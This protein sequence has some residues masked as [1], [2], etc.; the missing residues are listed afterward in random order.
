ME[1]LWKPFLR[2]KYF[3]K[4]W[5]FTS[6]SLLFFKQTNCMKPVP[7]FFKGESPSTGN[8]CNS[9]IFFTK[10]SISQFSRNLIC[11]FSDEKLQRLEIFTKNLEHLNSYW[12]H[13]SPCFC[14]FH[15]KNVTSWGLLNETLAV[16]CRIAARVFLPPFQMKK[17]RSCS[18]LKK[19]CSCMRK[20]L[21]KL[22]FKE[23]LS[24]GKW[25]GLHSQK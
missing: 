17:C 7:P 24:I 2:I 12:V 9:C 15:R 5:R 16:F 4:K 18:F 14:I 23:V 10:K 1:I 11:S 21:G 13:F 22:F 3:W 25:R 20:S 6:I 19:N 8:T